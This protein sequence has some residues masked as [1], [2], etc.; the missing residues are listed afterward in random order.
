MIAGEHVQLRAIE[1]SDLR[2]LCDWR[3][4]P[5]LRRYFREHRELNSDDQTRWFEQVVIADPSTIM[6]GIESRGDRT[7][8]GA[9]GLASIDW[10]SRTAELSLYLGEGY[11]DG[12]DAP[13]ATRLVLSYAFDVLDLQ[14]A[15]VEVYDYDRGKQELYEALGF[16]LEGRLREHHFDRGRRHDSLVYGL[17]RE[18]FAAAPG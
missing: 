9:C 13:E 15:W 4:D 7:L 1:R 17:L 2:S 11:V 16:K 12:A 6:F 14:R 3:N 18:E 8:L 5:D 10:V